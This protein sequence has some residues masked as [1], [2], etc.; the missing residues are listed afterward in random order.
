MI[1]RDL[2]SSSHQK[3]IICHYFLFRTKCN[4][5]LLNTQ[6][7]KNVIQLHLHNIDITLNSVKEK[8]A[9]DFTKKKFMFDVLIFAL[10]I[11][12]VAYFCSCYLEFYDCHRK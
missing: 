1:S 8:V 10:E 3:P 11:D 9:R 2:P 12:V 7:L 6:T 4:K 5:T